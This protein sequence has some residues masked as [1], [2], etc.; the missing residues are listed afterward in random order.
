MSREVSSEGE[1]AE[2]S[3]E[4]DMRVS[5]AVDWEA[6]TAFDG[7]VAGRVKEEVEVVAAIGAVP[8]LILVFAVA[9]DMLVVLLLADALPAATPTGAVKEG[10]VVEALVA[11]VPAVPT[12]AVDAV[13]LLLALTGEP[14]AGPDEGE[15]L[16]LRE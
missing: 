1:A 10:T 4:E 7:T 5:D 8:W 9:L 3:E 12:A 13:P 16:V 11:G 2:V 14:L 6:A 15:L